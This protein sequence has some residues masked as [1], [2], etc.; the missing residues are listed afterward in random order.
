M[1]WPSRL[2][3]LLTDHKAFLLSPVSGEQSRHPWKVLKKLLAEYR[4]QSALCPPSDS[5]VLQKRDTKRMT[6]M[7]LFVLMI[8]RIFLL[9]NFY[10]IVKDLGTCP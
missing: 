1:G 5:L 10:R 8:L 7:G 3:A 2:N 9:V 4:E 6:Q